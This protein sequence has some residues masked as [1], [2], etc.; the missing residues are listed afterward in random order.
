MTNPQQA[1]PQWLKI[2]SISPKI[3]N[4]TRVPTPTTPIK[5]SF[6]SFDHSNQRRKRSKGNLDRKRRR[7]TPAVCR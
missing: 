1:L 3:R 6:G 2:E 4:K 5:H 7:E